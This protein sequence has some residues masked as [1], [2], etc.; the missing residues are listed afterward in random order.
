MVLNNFNSKVVLEVLDKLLEED[1]TLYLSV[2]NSSC[3]R[4]GAN[5]H[6]GDGLA[7]LYNHSRHFLVLRILRLNRGLPIWIN[8]DAN[9]LIVSQDTFI[10]A[11][12]NRDFKPRLTDG[13]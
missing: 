2:V 5:T 8:S 3:E 10:K 12:K 1:E 7:L 13:Y 11:V 9:E 4:S 6:D